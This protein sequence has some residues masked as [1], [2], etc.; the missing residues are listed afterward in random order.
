MKA[1]ICGVT[2]QDG[3]LLAKLLLEKGYEVV[4]TSRDISTASFHNLKLL[5]INNKIKKVSMAL[6]DFRSVFDIV[7]AFN[8]NEI[9]NLAGQT[10]VG[11]SFCQPVEAMESITKG[12][13][14]L[15]VS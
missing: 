1:L 13:L 10:S 8:P 9:Y 14:V 3:S 11:L 4:G 6:N 7:Q 12:T 15:L 2:G 5:K